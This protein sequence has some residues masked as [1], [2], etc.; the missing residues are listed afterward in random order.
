MLCPLCGDRSQVINSR[1]YEDG[2]M[3]YRRRMCRGCKHRFSTVEVDMDVYENQMQVVK[4]ISALVGKLY[5]RQ[6]G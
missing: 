4:E 3:I 6:K 5:K 2:D 1:L